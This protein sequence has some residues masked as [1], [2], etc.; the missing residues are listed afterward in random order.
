MP[1]AMSTRDTFQRQVRPTPLAAAA[2]KPAVW[3]A[4]LMARQQLAAELQRGHAAVAQL[5]PRLQCLYDGARAVDAP[6]PGVP[7]FEPVPPPWPGAAGMIPAVASLVRLKPALLRAIQIALF[8]F[9]DYRRSLDAAARLP[10]P[11]PEGTVEDLRRKAYH[12]ATLGSAFADEAALAALFPRPQAG[13]GG[14][15]PPST[16][17]TGPE[18]A[19][20]GKARALLERVGSLLPALEAVLALIDHPTPPKLGELLAHEVRTRRA[21]AARLAQDKAA[22]DML[23]GVQLGH[24]VLARALAGEPEPTALRDMCE[25]LSRLVWRGRAHAVAAPLFGAAPA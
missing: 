21:L 20:R 8:R 23:R 11:V 2:P 6:L 13:V 14:L 5:G 12:L 4:E 9:H 15:V 24:G 3:G 1:G 16:A 17:P 22:V 19:S 7:D 18:D 10:D 25:R